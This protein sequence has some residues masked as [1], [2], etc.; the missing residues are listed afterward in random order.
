MKT[1][2]PSK[3]L[4][5]PRDAK[6]RLSWNAAILDN[7]QSQVFHTAQMERHYSLLAAG[8]QFLFSHLLM[9]L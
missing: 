5:V 1:N 8:L 3:K 7:K 4:V 2:N 9:V 6:M